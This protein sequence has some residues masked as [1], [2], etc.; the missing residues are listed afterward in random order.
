MHRP[1]IRTELEL[2]SSRS[3]YV[4]EFKYALEVLAKV[5]RSLCLILA[6]SGEN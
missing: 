4:R 6:L 3:L 5:N 1:L 2:K